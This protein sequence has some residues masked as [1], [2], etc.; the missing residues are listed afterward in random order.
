MALNGTLP[1][2]VLF[3]SKC[4]HDISAIESIIV[5]LADVNSPLGVSL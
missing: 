5:I 3:T 4:A 1:R 2:L